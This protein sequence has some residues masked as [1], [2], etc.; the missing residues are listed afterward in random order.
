MK[1]SRIFHDPSFDLFQ[2][3]IE[4]ELDD[5]ILLPWNQKLQI[6]TAAQRMN[7]MSFV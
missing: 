3:E 7:P 6:L 1:T 2:E 5:R 4:K